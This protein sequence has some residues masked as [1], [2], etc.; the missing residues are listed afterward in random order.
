MYEFQNSVKIMHTC[1]IRTRNHR[2]AVRPETIRVEGGPSDRTTDSEES[3][4]DPAGGA[5]KAY[6]TISFIELTCMTQIGLTRDSTRDEG[7]CRPGSCQWPGAA[8]DPSPTRR[9]ELAAF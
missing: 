8:V 5:R 6:S 7:Q 4:T 2:R 1:G 3:A 9:Q